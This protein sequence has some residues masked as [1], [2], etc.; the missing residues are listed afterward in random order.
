MSTFFIIKY[1]FKNKDLEYIQTIVNDCL[2]EKN[3]LHIKN[4]LMI[5]YGEFDIADSLTMDS[6]SL[7]EQLKDIMFNKNFIDPKELL[8]TNPIFEERIRK[9]KWLENDSRYQNYINNVLNS[10]RQSLRISYFFYKNSIKRTPPD[11]ILTQLPPII[12]EQLSKHGIPFIDN[13]HSK[14]H[15]KVLYSSTIPFDND[16]AKASI[17]LLL[18]SS[19][20][21]R[22]FGTN[23]IIRT[24][25]FK[26]NHSKT[27]PLTRQIK[28]INLSLQ[29][30]LLIKIKAEEKLKQFIINFNAETLEQNCNLTR[31]LQKAELL[32]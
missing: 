22:N 7:E 24:I 28:M 23:N 25:E 4:V 12:K 27:I 26:N 10:M 1:A 3:L 2:N 29:H 32:K 8:F 17:I 9:R 6:N 16:I 21:C 13:E 11:D 18:N 20:D 19:L 15:L 31:L 14:R 5:Y 30:K